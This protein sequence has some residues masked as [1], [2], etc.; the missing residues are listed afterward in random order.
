MINWNEEV[1]EREKELTIH[2]QQLL[3]IKSVLDEETITDGAPFG[4]GISEAY[5]WMLSLAD[6]DGFIT[7]DLDGYAGHIEFGDGDEIIGVLCHLD[8]VPEGGGW[9]SPPYSAEVR[10]GNIYAR[11]AIDDKGPTMAAYYAL[12]IIKELKLPIQKKIRIILGNDEESKWRCVEHYFKHE[13]MPMAGFAPDANFPL[14][15]A[16]KGICDFMLRPQFN[17]NESSV[18]YQFKSGERLNMVPE[19]ATCQLIRANKNSMR[20]LFEKYLMR[21]QLDGEVSEEEG[22]L[23]LKINGR[24]AHGSEPDKGINSGLYLANFIYSHVPLTEEDDRYFSLLNRYFYK[25]T[26]GEH[27]GIAYADE[28]KGAI[29]LNIGV[30]EYSQGEGE[31]GVNLRYPEGANFEHIR[32]TLV[33]VFS[34]HQLDLNI[35]TH[36]RPHAVDLNHPLIQVLSK[37]YKEHTGD[38]GKPIAIGGGTYARSLKA[39]VAFGPMF[40][41]QEDVAHQANEYISINH[42]KKA[43]AIYAQALFELAK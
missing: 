8:V 39:G 3:Q 22:R 20:L 37:V 6:G 9:T 41:G 17:K 15:Y 23:C 36:E 30:M 40:P 19:V 12:K 31:I 13:K 33:Q 28:D 27:I 29:T 4:K 11:G 32:Q 10:H 21:H 7:K 2:T 42:L 18:V 1:N 5:H 43:T 14:I 25:D 35:I 38:D 24:S 34:K 16:E 26:K